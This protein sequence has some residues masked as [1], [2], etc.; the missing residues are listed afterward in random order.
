MT[1]PLTFS[2]FSLE[3]FSYDVLLHSVKKNNSSMS[4]LV[5]NLVSGLKLLSNHSAFAE[6]I[7]M[8]FET[9]SFPKVEGFRVFSCQVR[10]LLDLGITQLLSRRLVDMRKQG[11]DGM[12]NFIQVIFQQVIPINLKGPVQLSIVCPRLTFSNRYRHVPNDVNTI[13][14]LFSRCLYDEYSR[15]RTQL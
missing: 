14:Y 12:K 5:K 10:L 3:L 13:H 2:C 15:N 6:T 11:F 1:F 7:A 9:L 8:P 4:D